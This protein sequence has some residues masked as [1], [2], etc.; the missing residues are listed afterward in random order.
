MFFI[1]I[2]VIIKRHDRKETNTVRYGVGWYR[3]VYDDTDQ[4]SVLV[5]VVKQYVM[6]IM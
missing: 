2:Q 5:Y 3:I 4:L 1:I 6:I